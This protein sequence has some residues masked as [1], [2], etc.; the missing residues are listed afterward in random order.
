MP[1]T[2]SPTTIMVPK[3][4][5]LYI[6]VPLLIGELA[7]PQFSSPTTLVLPFKGATVETSCYS[8]HRS[9]PCH[10]GV[11]TSSLFHADPLVHIALKAYKMLIVWHK[12]LAK[13]GFAIRAIRE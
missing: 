6:I 5:D 13:H 4:R 8:L 10:N 1:V 9:L 3:V 2:S 12:L 11:A 7:L